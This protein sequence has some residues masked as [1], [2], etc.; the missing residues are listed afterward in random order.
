ML[1]AHNLNTL[2]T[3]ESVSQTGGVE[4][5]LSFILFVEQGR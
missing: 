3:V 2:A 5:G 1:F 4:A